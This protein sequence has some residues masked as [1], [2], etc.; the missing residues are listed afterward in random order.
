MKAMRLVVLMLMLATCGGLMDSNGPPPP[1]QTVAKSV[2]ALSHADFEDEQTFAVSTSTTVGAVTKGDLLYFTASGTISTNK[3]GVVG[4]DGS[5][6]LGGTAYVL[7]NRPVFA[8]FG[9]INQSVFFI[10]REMVVI[11]PESGTLELLVNVCMS[12]PFPGP[13]DAGSSSACPT[14]GSFSV[15]VYSKLAQGVTLATLPALGDNTISA[16][17]QLQVDAAGGW[18]A[19]GLQL[20]KGQKT[21]VTAAGSFTTRFGASTADGT[22]G[23]GGTSFQLLNRFSNRL[24]GRVGGV[25]VDVGSQVVFL[26]PAGGQLE[27]MVN[28][29]AGTMGA[30]SVEVKKGVVPGRGLFQAEVSSF[31]QFASR[32]VGPHGIPVTTGITV[33]QGDPIVVSAS[34]TLA[35]DGL[36]G[37]ITPWGEAGLGGLIFALGSR[38]VYALHGRIGSQPFFL[39][40]EGAV[41]APASGQLELLVNGVPA[42]ATGTCTPDGGGPPCN[43]TLWCTI[44]G[45]FDAGVWA[46]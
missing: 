23:L 10:G 19:T 34:G 18:Q 29:S 30:L 13:F 25:V 2:F 16:T 42:C 36:S 27:L 45:T 4:P 9:R 28:H 1:G 39:G 44:T 15:S 3:V 20:D 21:F 33:D 35:R 8:L 14:T 32:T 46:P 41:L 11:V 12:V 37:S 40:G 22:G 5:P 17:T 7:V 38:P 24:Y 43:P 31:S 26:S 6:G